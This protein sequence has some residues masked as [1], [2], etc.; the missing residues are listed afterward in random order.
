MPHGI[1]HA[2]RN[3]ASGDAE[4][5]LDLPQ[6]AM[7]LCRGSLGDF[8]TLFNS[9]NGLHLSELCA[10]KVGMFLLVLGSHSQGLIPS[11]LTKMAI[12]R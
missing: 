5:A 8:R 1:R 12:T 6:W 7:P 10:L 11:W 4:S 3:L 2:G 9:S